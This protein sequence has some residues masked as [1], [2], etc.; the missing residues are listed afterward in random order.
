MADPRKLKTLYLRKIFLGDKE[1]YDEF[2]KLYDKYVEEGSAIPEERA[3]IDFHQL[4][5]VNEEGEW[6]HM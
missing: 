5:R 1:I 4:Y 2:L 3:W 6:E